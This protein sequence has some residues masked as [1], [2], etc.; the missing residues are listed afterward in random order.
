VNPAALIAWISVVAE[1]IRVGKTTYDE[2]A[3][4][5]KSHA[6]GTDLDTKAEDDAMLALMQEVIAQK[7]AEAA[8]EAGLV[9]PTP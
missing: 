1:L 9:D 8:K 5:F 3:S 4:L 7:R 6:H 2:V